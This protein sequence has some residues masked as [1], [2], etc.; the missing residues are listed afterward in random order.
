MAEV[1]ILPGSHLVGR[2]LWGLNF[3]DRYSLQVLGINR[4]GETLRRRI[5]RTRLQVGDQLLLQGDPDTIQ[6]LGSNNSFRVVS[7][8]LDILPETEKAPLS[9]AIFGVV[10]LL[11]SFNL[12][13]LPV[14]VMLGALAALVTRCITPTEAYRRVNWSA[15]LL[16]S[17]MLALGRAMEVS[18]LASLVADQIVGLIGKSNPILILGAFFLLTLF[19][20][21]PMSNQAAAVVIIPIAIQTAAQLNL[22]A[23]TFAVMIAVGASCSFITP[24]EPACLMVYGP[25]NY[26]FFDFVRV[27]SL[28]TLLIFGIA[29]L[30]VPWLWPM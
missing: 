26:R 20:T 3:R 16:I 25:G 30:M 17:C 29:L 6:G 4:K 1:I 27:G 5:S 10:I 22:N 9:L 18:G 8:K 12:L 19:L 23:R 24:L 15:W 14:G 13:S 2:T 7:G 21:Q 11:V 28:L